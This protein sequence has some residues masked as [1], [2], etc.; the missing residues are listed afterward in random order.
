[1]IQNKHEYAVADEVDF[2]RVRTLLVARAQQMQH[3]NSMSDQQI[4]ELLRQQQVANAPKIL[5]KPS[6][7]KSV[8]VP[9]A[10][11]ALIWIVLLVVGTIIASVLQEDREFLVGL[12]TGMLVLAPILV[13]TLFI[14]YIALVIAHKR[15]KKQ[16][17][18]K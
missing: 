1:M 5:A 17:M 11:Y 14:R 12:L 2:L 7:I 3:P 4:E 13:L 6:L 15:S 16:A 8:F 9:T 10:S 18:L